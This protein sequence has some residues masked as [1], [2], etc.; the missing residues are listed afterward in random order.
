MNDQQSVSQGT[1]DG[2]VLGSP[3]AACTPPSATSLLDLPAA[4]LDDISCRAL[5]LG[6]TALARTCRAFYDA[7]LRHAP[8]FCIPADRQR[9]EQLLTVRVVAALRARTSRFSVYIEDKQQQLFSEQRNSESVA[10]ILAKLGSCAAAEACKLRSSAVNRRDSLMVIDCAPGLAQGLLDSFPCLTAL[11]LRGYAINCSDQASLLSHPQLALQLQQ[12]DLISTSIKH[13]QQPE[14]EAVFHGLRLKQLSLDVE[15]YGNYDENYINYNVPLLPDLRS[16]A[17]HLTHLHLWMQRPLELDQIM[18]EVA[19]LTQLQVL[20]ISGLREP[21]D[22]ADGIFDLARVLWTLPQV[23]TR[24][25]LDTT[26]SEC[27]YLNHLL[28]ATGLTSLQLGS[29]QELTKSWADAPC[30]WQQLE[31]TG[32]IDCKSLACLPLHSLTQ[33]LVFGRLDIAVCE[34]CPS[35]LAAVRNLTLSCKVPVR[36]NSLLLDTSGSNEAATT[37]TAAAQQRM[38]VKRLVQLLQEVQYRCDVLTVKCLKDVSTA[39]VTAL[40]PLCRG[41]V[42]LVFESGSIKPSLVFWRQLV[43]LVPSMQAVTFNHCLIVGSLIACLMHHQQPGCAVVFHGLRL[44]QLRL[45]TGSFGNYGENIFDINERLLPD[46]KPLVQHLTHL[47]LRVDMRRADHL[48]QLAFE[49]LPLAQLQLLTLSNVKD[50][51][52]SIGSIGIESLHCLALVLPQLHTLQL[53]DTTLS[54]WCYL[55]PLLAATQV[56]SLQLGSSKEL[57][58]SL[59]DAPCSWQ[60]LELTG[61]VDCKSIACLPLHSLTQP[62]VLGT[63]DI[64]V[65]EDCPSLLRPHLPESALA[66]APSA[67]ETPPPP[68]APGP[69]VSRYLD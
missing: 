16:L 7:N 59:S 56:T 2:V 26:L 66:Q 11:S 28:A 37:D 15:H 10:R 68:A 34:D 32:S 3:L 9:C 36:I 14:F 48:E 39:D 1:V 17:Q 69:A 42:H 47:H 55:N 60:Q 50:H 62:L 44:K 18:F 51:C 5:Q 46:L 13:H 64:A 21:L 45:D 38:E 40:A 20:T 35:L 41:C 31:L 25:L 33:P 27:C 23:H 30:S 67:Q 57:T 6:A 52:D 22:G 43:Q 12:L 53:P 65:Y 4:L 61:S 58:T 8:A 49:V 54:K 63:L 29:F 24:Q 19:S